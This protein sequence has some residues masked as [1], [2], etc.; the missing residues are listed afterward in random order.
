VLRLREQENSL[1][2]ALHARELVESDVELRRRVLQPPAQELEMATGD[3]DRG[4]ELVRHI[5]Q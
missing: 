2:D 3:R 1:D 5:V 4:A